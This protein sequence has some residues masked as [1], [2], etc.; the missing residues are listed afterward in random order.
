M[1]IEYDGGILITMTIDS[2]HK[3]NL[4][5][6]D[7]TKSQSHKVKRKNWLDRRSREFQN[8]KKRNKK[9]DQ[10]PHNLV[11]ESAK[12]E[13]NIPRSEMPIVFSISKDYNK[14]VICFNEVKNME[15]VI[16]HN[17]VVE[18]DFTQVLDFDVESLIYLLAII[19]KI[20]EKKRCEVRILPPKDINIIDRFCQTGFTEMAQAKDWINTQTDGSWNNNIG[21]KLFKITRGHGVDSSLVN[22]VKT[23]SI[24]YLGLSHEKVRPIYDILIELMSNKV[25]HSNSQYWYLYTER[26]VDNKKRMKYVFFDTGSGI[27]NTVRKRFHENVL[28]MFGGIKKATDAS[29]IKSVLEGHYRPRTDEDFRGQ[30]LPQVAKNLNADYISKGAINS[31]RGR[32]EI[33][34]KQSGETVYL[35]HNFARRFFGTLFCWEM[36]STNVG[37]F[38]HDN[39]C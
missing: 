8:K 5:H 35:T 4:N 26:D 3:E 16:K 39:E 34:L 12:R 28:R 15:Q 19:D 13:E 21:E 14:S 9:P 7:T 20:K 32:C 24:V 6:H 36:S 31:G 38:Y 17:G 37:R 11:D 25:A 2:G 10:Q 18:L 22:G 1:Q 33:R 23:Y 30:G 29:L 27:P